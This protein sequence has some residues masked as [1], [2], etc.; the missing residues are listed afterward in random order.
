MFGLL[1]VGFLLFKVAQTCMNSFIQINPLKSKST[2]TL[3]V[4]TLLWS[5]SVVWNFGDKQ[6]RCKCLRILDPVLRC[7]NQEL[8]CP[9]VHRLAPLVASFVDKSRDQVTHDSLQFVMECL[10]TIELLIT[11]PS[12]TEHSLFFV[13]KVLLMFFLFINLGFSFF[14]ILY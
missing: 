9:A 3:F 6:V 8:T 10:N 7:G 4:N 13:L 11:L 2:K 1:L 5:L 12:K 14:S